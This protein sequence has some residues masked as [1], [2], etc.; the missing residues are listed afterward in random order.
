MNRRPL[1]RIIIIVVLCLLC[2]FLAAMVYPVLAT[3]LRKYSGV[4]LAFS[5]SRRE[6]ISALFFVLLFTVL[7]VVTIWLWKYIPVYSLRRKIW[8][9]LLLS[10]CIGLS[11]YVRVAWLIHYT[12]LR[13]KELLPPASMYAFP[14]PVIYA[15]RLHLWI[16]LMGAFLLAVTLMF[17]LL[18]EH[19]PA[20]I[21]FSF[22]N[23]GGDKA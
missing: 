1:L 8:S 22:E 5:G 13:H 11:V 2:F 4:H 12:Q 17:A 6:L 21:S 15:E 9:V 10:G 23:E 14:A 7:P 16:F 19:Q 18:R 3:V 20:V